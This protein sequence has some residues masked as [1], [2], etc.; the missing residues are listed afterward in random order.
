MR[1]LNLILE[2]TFNSESGGIKNSNYFISSVSI[3]PFI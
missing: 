2:T 1:L 3:D